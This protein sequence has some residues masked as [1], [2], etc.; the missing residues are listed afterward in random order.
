[1]LLSQ[2]FLPVLKEE[3][4]EAQVTS[5]KLMLRS[6]MIRQQA[7][8]IYTWLPLG[9]KVLKNIENIVSLNMNKA[10]ALE[11]LMP[12]IQPAHLWM[13]SGR[14]NNYGK[15]MLKFQDRHDNTLLFGPTNEDMITDIFRHNIKSYKDLPKNLYHIQWKFRDEIRPR[16]GVMRGRE[17][18]M[19]DAYSF[20]INEEN[21]VKTYNQMYKAY[22]NTFRDLGVFAIPVIADNGPIGGKLSHE[23]HIIAETGES[24]IYYDKRFKT[25]KDNPD[26]DVDEI[27]SWYA[28]AE[29]KHDINKLPISEQEITSSKGIEVGHI[30]YIGSKYSVNMKALIN[31]EHGKLAP[32]EMSSYGIGISRLVAAII[33]ANCDEKGI[34]WPFSVAPFKVSLIN[35]NIHDSK[36]VEL[37]AKAYKDLSDKNIEVLYDDTEA[38]PGSKFATHDLIGSPHQIII[39][40]KK[41]ANNIV[42]LKDRKSGNIEDIEVENLINYIK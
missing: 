38:R 36:C 14:F 12:C 32:V 27:K 39:G 11:V 31:D 23:F 6:G 37:A 20:D 26:I 29:E 34:I 2:Y 19:K 24:T 15:E 3:P 35:L 22:I 28:A 25:L 42:E 13:E 5:H 41:A 40:P 8:G 30:F 16:F 10:G 17:F 7:A 1:M 4:S 18:L 33:E 9:L 21:A